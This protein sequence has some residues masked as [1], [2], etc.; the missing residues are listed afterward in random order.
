[1]KR[2][3]IRMIEKPFKLA[4]WL[5]L[6]AVST[7]IGRGS[8]LAE[9]QLPTMS[10]YVKLP[11]F[12]S[13]SAKPN[14][15]IML[16]NSG[17]MNNLAYSDGYTGTPYNGTTKSF[18]VV[19]ERDDM[20]ENS[21]G[22]LR[23]GS[24]SGNDLDFGT[25]YVAVRFQNVTIPNSATITSARI[26]FTSKGDWTGI[27]TSLNIQGEA[28]DDAAFLDVTSTY[29]ISS[30]TMT[31]ENVAWNPG[32]W[33]DGTNY[34]TPDLTTIVQE[35]V[36]RTGWDSNNA[37]LFRIVYSGFPGSTSGHRE[38]RSR[39]A[40]QS[41]AA[42]LHVTYIDQSAGTRYYGYFNPD[43]FYTQ[44][45]NVF[46]PAYKKDKYNPFTDTWNVK[47]LTGSTAT[48]SESDIAPTTKADGLWDGNWMNWL[49]MRRVDVLRK[50]LMGGKATSR[51]GNGNQQNQAESAVDKGYGPF[52]KYFNSKNGSATSPYKGGYTYEVT[53]DG[54]VK[55]TVGATSATYKLDIQKDISIEPEDFYEGNLAGVLQRIGDRARWGNMWFNP[56][57][58]TGNSGGSV[59]NPIDNG[60][61]TNF[62]PGLQKQVCNTWTPLA[63]SMYVA[64]QYFSQ[65]EV[66]SGL[67]YPD[68]SQLFNIGIESLK[69]PY[70]DKDE[71]KFVR[72][73]KS[74]VLLLTDGASTK[75]SKIP[76]DWKDFDKDS[77]DKD[78]CDESKNEN[79]DYPSG[80]T[81]YL[82]DLALYA[83]T[84]DLR[85]DLEGDQNIYLYTVFAFDDDPNARSLLMDAAR[86]GG[87]EDKNGDGK[88]NG[89]YSSPAD[90]RLEWDLDGDKIPDTYFEASNGYLLQ[91]E[92]MRAINE[93]LKRASSGTAASVVSNSRSGEGAVYQ[94]IFYPATTAKQ[95]TVKWVGQVHALLSDAHGNLREDTNHNHMLDLGDDYFIRF[96][97]ETLQKY[98]DSN[99]N[100][101]FDDTDEGPLE[102]DKKTEFTLSDIN[103]LWSSNEWLNELTDAV[104]QRSYD[105]TDKQ[106][107]IFTFVDADGDMVA[108]SKEILSFT[109]TSDP[110]WTQ[111]TD[112]SNYYA[113]IHAYTPFTPPIAT[114]DTNFR[115]MVSH[116]IRRVINFTRGQDQPYEKIGSVAYA[117]FR[118][119]IIDYDGDGTDETWRLGDVV[120]STP[121]VVGPPAEDF[122]LIYR[123]KGYATFF[124]RYKDR[125][126]VVYV[127]ANDGMVH[128]FNS[129]FFDSVNNGF[130]TKPVDEKGEEIKVGGPYHAFDIGAELWAYIPYNLL[131]HLYWLT[132]LGYEHIY[133]NDLQPRIFD[134]RIYSDKASDDPVNPNGWAT[135]MI[136]GMRFGGGKI[137]ADIDKEDG[138]Y[139]S[140][141]DKVM[142]SSFTIMDITNP[143][144]PPKLLAEITFPD[145]G[146]TTCHP[147]VIPMRDFDIL[148]HE[149]KDNQWYLIFG[150][151]PISKDSNSIEGPNTTS[152]LAG[153][154][155]QQG[156]L[157]AI[158]LVE[159]ATNNKLVTLTSSGP[160][161]YSASAASD[162]YYLIKFPETESLV[163]KPIAVDWDL[164]FN[165]DAAYFGVTYGNHT[166]GWNGKMRRIVMDNGTS[167]TV[168]TNW[169]LNSTLLDLTD[170]VS[171]KLANGQP[172][173]A[174]ATA[175][176]DAAGD[177]WLFFGTGRFYS[178][179]DKL[180][181]DQQAYYGVKEPFTEAS[182]GTKSFNYKE[183][184]FSSL[185]DVSDIK[186]YENGDTLSGFSG[187][188]K[189]LAD[190]IED[191]KSGWRL[192]FKVK[193]GQRNL[194]EAV[195]AGDVLTFT[196]Y[197][198]SDDPCSIAGESQVYAV[199]YR[200]GTAYIYSIIGLDTSDAVGD[201]YLVKAIADLGPGMTIT[202]NIHIGRE[203]G[204][205]AYIQ[206][207]TGAIKPLEEKNPGT[208]KSG[209]VPVR[210]DYP[211]CP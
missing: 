173:V 54:Y 150:S 145:L 183:V 13:Y 193:T 47:T 90:E 119:R 40:G 15:M 2:N 3:Y 97:D 116:Q 66:A 192:D 162:P 95:N 64:I 27:T 138:G 91:E 100:G 180:G 111:V 149:E 174:S 48:L 23:D 69:D 181:T 120:Y 139:K 186:V 88:P 208:V 77:K 79:C 92:L 132:N 179:D 24:A 194:G 160:K 35:I 141:V 61:S 167:P 57:T 136:T 59:Q 62:L 65:L 175:G 58:G 122:D 72:C 142:T 83:R 84:Q 73:A 12:A 185:M 198:P 22:V 11:P 103:F 146:F 9:W 4:A 177:H 107:Y 98:K 115:N 152:L 18:P 211:T 41:V 25:D 45:S 101:I 184:S 53:R 1:M 19:L 89:T 21:S 188:F 164:D 36:D 14:I 60:F 134:A 34:D 127:G 200:T 7:C 70:W 210:P 81:D 131:P 128:A 38:A 93:I 166:K 202:P 124:Q 31:T 126:N 17:S 20:E 42:V 151:G 159:L 33:I 154:S 105:S 108:D 51:T 135:V 6:L 39:E 197:V 209:R 5:M 112:P 148:T 104:N 178:Q 85:A 75:D 171:A 201:D 207:S 26:E 94:S 170:N 176:T 117:A 10:D 56:G 8:A 121:T 74:F 156:V 110:T 205:E 203:K 158:D 130:V 52:T 190:Y 182:D 82:D 133:Y 87:F 67:D 44:S 63:E 106:R 165:T 68:Q 114:S 129:G 189:K 199:Y 37:M 143:E 172:I 191:N 46:W 206:T 196:T 163:S 155:D 140:A 147:G 113:Y 28:S 29:N 157:Y 43:Y 195:L 76:S 137:A 204:S 55:V 123:D 49:S 153:T 30:R 50:V 96:G 125:R 168:P 32:D 161:T 16:D 102:I 71:Q 169:T 118:N 99:A 86:N 144:E 109:A 78:S 80:G 187:N